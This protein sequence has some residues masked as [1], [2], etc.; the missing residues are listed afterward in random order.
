MG[1][2]IMKILNRLNFCDIHT[3]L[4][5]VFSLLIIIQFN[6]FGTIGLIGYGFMLV[7]SAIC[8]IYNAKKKHF[9]K[10]ITFYSGVL[11]YFFSLL[12]PLVNGGFNLIGTRILQLF[13]IMLLVFIDRNGNEILADIKSLTKI[14]TVAGFIMGLSSILLTAFVTWQQG[15]IQQLPQSI[16]NKL[17]YLAGSFS[18]RITGLAANANLT[19]CYTMVGAICSAYLLTIETNLK[20][21]AL[22]IANTFLSLYIIFIATA[23]RTTMLAV[24]GA[25]ITYGFLYFFIICKGN[26]IKRSSFSKLLFIVLGISLIIIMS[27][28]IVPSLKDFI[29]NKIIRIDSLSTGSNRLQCYKSAWEMGHGNRLL[30]F[31][32]A[33]FTQQTGFLHTH[34]VFLEV[35]SFSGLLGFIPFVI[36]ITSSAINIFKNIKKCLLDIL[37]NDSKCA[38]CFIA[39]IFTAFIIWGITENG[40]IYS[41]AALSFFTQLAFGVSNTLAHKSSSI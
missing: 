17:F 14:M 2:G 27:L 11:F 16:A 3:C 36:Y 31:S 8:I 24:I 37:S 40:A 15:Y 29:L 25:A 6:I 41:L 22:S 23:S 30:G 7:Y 32:I 39:T 10:S 5:I 26:K 18:N 28:F 20:W 34:N 9:C 33:D 4:R 13:L 19:A 21:K 1:G 12:G 38:L 35:L